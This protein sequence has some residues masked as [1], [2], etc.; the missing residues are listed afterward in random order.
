MEKQHFELTVLR[1]GFAA[2]SCLSSSSGGGLSMAIV[3]TCFAVVDGLASYVSSVMAV[4]VDNRE[5]GERAR[6]CR[7]ADNAGHA[8]G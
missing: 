5:H 8:L 1:L 2:V 7:M 4:V 3:L 6:V